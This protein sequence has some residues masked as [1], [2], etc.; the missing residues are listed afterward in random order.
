MQLSWFRALGCVFTVLL[1]IPN[2]AEA[3]TD[4]KLVYGP[5]DRL[6]VYEVTDQML[7]SLVASTC[8]L[9]QA[10]SLT[11]GANDTFI[12]S[13]GAYTNLGLPPCSDEPFKDQ[14]PLGFCSG[15]LVGNDLIATAGHC[16]LTDIT[17]TQFVFGHDMLDATTDVTTFDASQV[18]TGVEIVDRVLVGSED[19]MLVRVDRTVDAP[20]AIPLPIR[21]EGAVALGDPIGVIGHP[22]GLPKKIAFGSTTEV[23]GI[24]NAAY[25]DAN[26]D[27]YGGNSGS[28]IFNQTTLL[29]EGILVRGQTD[30]VNGGGCF[31]SNMLSD[32][33]GN[34]GQYEECTRI[35]L[36]ANLIP[37]MNPIM[38][39]VNGDNVVNSSDIQNVINE[40]LG[41]MTG[42]ETD[43]NGD[44]VTNSVDI[45]IVINIVLGT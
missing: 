22:S 41:S 15:F 43:L 19:W 42:L 24:S 8:T 13:P 7:L 33:T 36:L 5:D 37:V 26:V 3:Q 4:S 35:S 20:G 11:P 10:G 30:Y 40:V 45:Q 32:E 28:P 34:S 16:L 12:S 1:F 17:S 21:R 29:V 25:F 14:R 6:D 18:Y 39:D 2:M 44:L 31:R 27:T 38:G 23:K 9:I